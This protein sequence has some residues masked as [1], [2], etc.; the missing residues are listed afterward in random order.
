VTNTVAAPFPQTW[1]FQF[2]LESAQA[3]LRM[4][5]D[6]PDAIILASYVPSA[7]ALVDAELDATE[8]ISDPP[9]QPVN[10]AAVFLTVELYR[11]KD[12]PFGVLNAWSVDDVMIRVGPDVMRS[13]RSMILPFKQRFGVA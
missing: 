10:H 11:R 2:I 8:V 12:A 5:W 13:V 3:I 7:T 6:D 1:D 4:E 9:P